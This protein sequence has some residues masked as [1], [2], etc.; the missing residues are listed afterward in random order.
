MSALP[1]PSLRDLALAARAAGERARA[2]ALFREAGDP[3]SRNDAALELLALGEVE[4]ARRTAEALAG[5]RPDFAPARRTLGLVARAAGDLDAAL[6]H[7]R[8]ATARDRADLWSA[9][10]AAETLRALG[11]GE[12]ADAALRALAGGTPLPHALRALGAAARARGN[13]EDAL[14][15]LR[16]AADLLPA[17]PWFLLDHAEALV[18]LERLD[19]ADVALRALVQHHPHF[20]GARR[21]LM[22]LAA[23]RGD[24][25]MRLDEARALAALDPDAGALDL[26]DVLLER[27]ERA[28]AETVC[29]RHLVR[30]G[31][32]PRPLR[33]LARGARQAGDAER[34]LAHLRAAARLLPAD[35][36]LRAECAGEA[37]ALGRIAQARADA[38]AAL[39]IDPAAP[40]A[41]RVLALVARA[42][43]REA[44]ALDR[45]R[46]LWADG[47]GPS[48]AGFD[49][50]ADLRADGSFTD[51]A[52]VY[53]RLA[54]RPD[55]APEA[56]VERALLA[57]RLDGIAGARA[58]LGEAL[59]LSPG[60]PRALL[61]LGDM[62]RELGRFEAAAAAY[63]AALESR[64]GFGW[65]HVGLALLAEA[66]GNADEAVSA[67]SAAI[68]ADPG[69]SHP[70]ILLA[71]RLAERGDGDDARA[72]LA[73]LP[74]GDPRAA[75]AALAL[76]RIRRL[77]GD[78]AG[79]LRV[80]EDA[81]RRWPDRPD[82]AVETAEEALRQGWPEAALAWLSFGE[83]RHPGHPGLLEARARLAL[84]RDDLEAATALFDEAATADPGRLGPPLMLARLAAM[85]GD[86]ASALERF[87]AA[88]R[89]FGER[90]ELTLARAE[91]LR[92][93]GRIAEAERCFDE[94]LAR[95][96]VPAVA[97]AAALAAI[98]GARLPRAEALLSGLTTATR[99]DTARLHFALAQL[100]A[101]RWDFDHAIAEGE[102]AVRLQ[103]AD[104]WYRNRLAHAALPALDLPRA[105][106]AL[107]EGAALE[108]G[109]NALRGK[110]A[111][112]SQSH[113]GQL[114]DEFRLDAEALAALQA[115]LAEPPAVRLA[116]I[117]ACLRAFPD[118][119]ASSVLYL[120]E[121]RRQGALATRVGDGD[122]GV[123]RAIHQFWTDDAVPADVAAY[124]ATW[125]DLNPGF[126][127]RVWSEREAAGWLA[128]YG[129]PATA[130][131][132]AR[133]REPAMKADLFRLAL[134]AREG[135]VWVDADDRCL[136]PIAPLLQRGAGLLAYQEDLGSVGNNV[137]AARPGHPLVLRALAQASEAVNRGDGD[138]LWLA[139]GPGLLTRV[140]V[141]A[142]ARPSSGE[143]DDALLLERAECLA[144][145]AI[146]CLAAYKASERHWSRTAFGRGRRA[147][148][149]AS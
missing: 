38:E 141:D 27:G 140:W 98:E 72:L 36:T 89:R 10:D 111:N 78:G 25:A 16:V 58:R 42:E 138:I 68:A 123:P 115:A 108:A 64:P 131:A 63:R 44:E 143:A 124:M 119:T 33:Q 112:P 91:T 28:E 106:R 114:L 48:Q 135:G 71:L 37:L 31:A 117:A 20:A 113:Y 54:E 87:E 56:L 43:G 4:D 99:A 50:G 34:A 92:Q 18:A 147:K 76:A 26:A 118:H 57:R 148:R 61:C 149:M 88:A 146:H 142:L 47:A 139:T 11:R 41:H 17:D 55:A 59:R 81:T 120:I 95:A 105:A 46:A 75:E 62:E 45:M 134:L 67:L 94:S 5:E 39:A 65:A 51:A 40:R 125:R 129:P 69:E 122:G 6:H 32:T 3:W 85:R 1:T 133:A 21:A 126:T 107:Q 136:R 83:A 82:L 97:I 52:T 127:H 24:A 30:R 86:P 130:A 2:L 9:Y 104:G 128:A 49:L 84:S 116:A 60:H 93:L 121:A 8:A 73:G 103:P 12:E 145:V 137:L 53:E 22:R 90:P 132:F 144:H 19:E 15:A 7:F 102:A 66:R 29:V 110:S 13:A 14:A 100:A 101:A 35:A 109:A 23:R 96:R 70:R 74:P 79:A 80:L 77:D